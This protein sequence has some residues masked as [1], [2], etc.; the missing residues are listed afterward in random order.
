ML[1]FQVLIYKCTD[2]FHFLIRNQFY[3]M[4][5]FVLIIFWSSIINY[6]SWRNE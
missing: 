6:W 5:F 2:F 4:L 3:H 1:T